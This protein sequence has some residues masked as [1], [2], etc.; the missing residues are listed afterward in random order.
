MKIK[1]LILFLIIS[2]SMMAQSRSASVEK[3]VQELTQRYQLNEQ[4][5]AEMYTILERK[6]R[7]LA[8]IAELE[9]TDYRVYLEKKRIIRTHTEG[10]IRRFLSEEQRQIQREEQL[11]YRRTTSNTIKELQ[12]AGKTKEEIE[13]ILLERGY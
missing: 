9:S 13:L 10:S 4:Q 12:A 8:E 1:M 6:E 5:V 11:A 3:G 2:G 7:N